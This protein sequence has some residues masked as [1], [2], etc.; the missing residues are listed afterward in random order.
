MP[1]NFR[2]HRYPLLLPL[3]VWLSGWGKPRSAAFP[4][5]ETVTANI[6]ANGCYFHMSKKP[7]VGSAV[8]MEIA[9]QP[10]ANML[11]RSK[12]VVSGKIVRVDDEPATGKTGVA[13]QFGRQD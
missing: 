8:H 9:M 6:S 4:H 7:E 11:P 13:C 3:R 10:E 5:E 2:P 1:R 12:M